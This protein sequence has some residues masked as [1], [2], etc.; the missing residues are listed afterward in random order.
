MQNP[1]YYVISQRICE[2]PDNA[3]GNGNPLI[4]HSPNPN[5]NASTDNKHYADYHVVYGL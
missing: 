1:S 3:Q 5:A 2:S 4:S